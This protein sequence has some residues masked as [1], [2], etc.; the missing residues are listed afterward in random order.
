VAPLRETREVR[1]KFSQYKLLALFTRV[2]K[3]LH[4][5]VMESNG[6]ANAVDNSAIW[7]WVLENRDTDSRFYLAENNKTSTRAVTNFSM[8]VKTSAGAVTIPSMQLAG[9][10]SRWVVTDYAVGNETLL[11]S[12][13]E[14]ATYGLFDSPVLVF[15]LKEGQTGDFAFKSPSNVTFDTHGAKSDIASTSANGTYAR[16]T[17]TQSKGAT[18][19]KFSNE[20]LAYLLDIPSAWTF[21]APPT[22]EDPNV[23]P[24]RHIFIMGPY[25]VRSASLLVGTVAVVGDNANATTIEV[26]AGPNVDTISW[27]GKDLTTFKTPYG[28]L[29]ASLEG[30]AQREI[31]LPELSD[32][33]VAD[34]SPEVQPSYDDSNWILANR[35]TTLSSVKPLTIPVLFSSDYKFYTGAKIYRGYFSSKSAASLNITVQGGVAAGW[36]A[37]LNGQPIGYHPGN[38]SLTSTT[39]LLSF[40]N[41]TLKSEGNVLTVVT[42]YTGHDQVRDPDVRTACKTY[43]DFVH[44]HLDLNWPS[45]CREPSRYPW[46]PAP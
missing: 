1:D 5:T 42:D 20:V 10:Q 30:T 24:D 38:V 6:T 13:A 15:Y 23:T 25:L 19:V 17:Y 40:K 39:A 3:G 8:T 18:V 21:F 35:T 32:F 2:S 28:S 37:W 4:N 36:N 11:Y 29:T 12:S 22:T 7:T 14:I 41:V 46:C 34:S 45:G 44:K 9:R 16:F 27:N 33:K 43:T 26:Y 31:H